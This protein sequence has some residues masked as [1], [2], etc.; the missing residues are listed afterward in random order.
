MLTDFVFSYVILETYFCFLA[1][2]SGY[3]MRSQLRTYINYTICICTSY[4]FVLLHISTT[5]SSMR[6][7]LNSNTLVKCRV[8]SSPP[9]VLHNPMKPCQANALLVSASALA[10]CQQLNDALRGLV[11]IEGTCCRT[12]GQRNHSVRTVTTMKSS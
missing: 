6:S 1:A 5:Y 7:Y 9:G 12:E 11:F 8:K 3:L 10:S 4:V 2:I